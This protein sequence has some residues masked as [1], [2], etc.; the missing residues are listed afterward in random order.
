MLSLVN[1]ADV[2]AD[3][4]A[5]DPRAS[6]ASSS[7][8]D[9]DLEQQP[10]LRVHDRRLPRGD[11]E[12]LG[13]ELPGGVGEEAAAP[14]VH[15]ARD[16]GVR[17]VV[18]LQAPPVGGHLDDAVALAQ[19]ELPELAGV[20]DAARE[21]AADTDDGD[22]EHDGFAPRYQECCDAVTGVGGSDS[23]SPIRSCTAGGSAAP[24][25]WPGPA[26]RM[27]RR[28]QHGAHQGGVEDDGQRR[29]D[30]EQLEEADLAGPEGDEVDRQQ[31]R[32]RADDPAG[33]GEARRPPRRCCR[34]CR[35]APP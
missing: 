30:A 16:V 19:Q 15:A 6:P 11:P 32:R 25:S 34:R 3:R 22:V 27:K 31:G 1:A 5:A 4:A 14:G 24:T 20:V 28:D 29:A 21:A 7:A 33:A 9:G 35:R 23:V 8:S 26:R 18:A 10:L 13:V 2:D 17:V 12:E